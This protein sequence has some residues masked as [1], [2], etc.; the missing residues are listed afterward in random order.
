MISDLN[1]VPYAID[2][3]IKL[4]CDAAYFIVTGKIKIKK[5][6]KIRKKKGKVTSKKGKLK[7]KKELRK[8]KYIWKTITKNFTSG[9]MEIQDFKLFWKDDFNEIMKKYGMIFSGL[10]LIGVR[11]AKTAKA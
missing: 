3:L 11:Y 2:Q 4:K 6:I 1:Q 9:I 5:R 10:L 7:R 8:Y